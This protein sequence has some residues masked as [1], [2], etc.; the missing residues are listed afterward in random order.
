MCKHGEINVYKHE[1]VEKSKSMYK[2]VE[3]NV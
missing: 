3:I 2:H 1:H